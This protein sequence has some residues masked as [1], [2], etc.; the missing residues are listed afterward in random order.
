VGQDGAVLGALF[1][2]DSPLCPDPGNSYSNW[3]ARQGKRHV[4]D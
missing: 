4:Q 3:L 1:A 2:V